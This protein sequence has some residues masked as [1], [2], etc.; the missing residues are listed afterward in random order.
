MVMCM[1]RLLNETQFPMVYEIMEQS[2]PKEERRSYEGQR[3]LLER[4]EYK[5][6]G[7][8]DCQGRIIGFLAVWELEGLLFIEHFAVTPEARNTGVGTQLLGLLRKEYRIPMCLEVEL[9]VDDL[10]RRRIGFYER[11]G[12]ALLPF[13]YEQPSLGEGRAPV[14]LRIMLAGGCGDH[15]TFRKVRD[16]LYTVVYGV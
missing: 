4:E 1:L 14:P 9:P 7:A 3:A 8:V 13:P 12:F 6:Y 15:E 5:L 11:N 16:Q 10:T 2:F